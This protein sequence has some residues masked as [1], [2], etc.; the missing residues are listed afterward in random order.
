MTCSF[1]LEIKLIKFDALNAYSSYGRARNA[2]K[3]QGHK[4]GR[5]SGFKKVNVYLSK[6]I[7]IIKFVA[8]YKNNLLNVN[9]FL[10]CRFFSFYFFLCILKKMT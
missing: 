2:T 9:L 5:V 6:K 3:M 4:E 10:F 1:F 8:S 7:T